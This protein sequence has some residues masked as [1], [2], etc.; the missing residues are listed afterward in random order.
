MKTAISIPDETFDRA[1]RRAAE[2]GMSRSE[3]F[4]QAAQRYLNDLEASSVTAQIDHALT[5]AGDDD[6]AAVAARAGRRLA[7]KDEW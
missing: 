4:T 1:S 5:V 7:R 2:L 6:S 3:F